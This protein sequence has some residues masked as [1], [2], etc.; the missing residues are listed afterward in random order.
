MKQNYSAKLC[1][2]LFF[3]ELILIFMKNPFIKKI[4]FVVILE[5]EKVEITFSYRLIKTKTL[6]T[7]K[8]P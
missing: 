8:I 2:V 1:C 3:V 7:I 5:N 6:E 4:N